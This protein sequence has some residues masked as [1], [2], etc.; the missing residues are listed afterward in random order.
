MFWIKKHKLQIFNQE[1]FNVKKLSDVK[2]IKENYTEIWNNIAVFQNSEK[3]TETNG[4]DANH[5]KANIRTN[6]NYMYT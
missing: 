5:A 4:M 3:R 1:K 2:F 6:V